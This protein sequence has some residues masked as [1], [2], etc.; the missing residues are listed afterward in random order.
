MTGTDAEFFMINSQGVLS[1]RSAPN[2]EVAKDKNHAGRG[3]D[4]ST[5]LVKDDDPDTADSSVI[6]PP[7][8]A[9][10]NTYAITVRATEK[11]SIS[12]PGRAEWTE[13]EVR[14]EVLNVEEKGK[15]EFNWMEPE[16]G[17]ADN[18]YPGPILTVSLGR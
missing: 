10:D 3:I 13:T 18:G 15:V 1:F 17:C 2:F 16:V 8:D 4:H 12:Y 7:D 14:V 6:D 5:G 9:T 11:R